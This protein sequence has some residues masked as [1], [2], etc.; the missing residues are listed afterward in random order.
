MLV[1]SDLLADLGG[2]SDG[3]YLTCYPLPNASRHVLARTWSAG[4]GYRPG[5][6]WTHSL[7]LDYQALAVFVDLVALEPLLMRSGDIQRGRPAKPLLVRADLT[8]DGPLE[9]GPNAAIAIEGLYRH[10]HDAVTVPAV[11]RTENDLLA[12]ALW[13]QMWPRLRREFT[14][15]TGVGEG[16]PA[17]SEDWVLRFAR[18]PAHPTDL[19][20]GLQALLDD[21]PAPGQTSLRRFLSRYAVEA[22]EPRKIA[23]PLAELWTMPPVGFQDRLRAVR[24]LTEDTPLPRL[25]RDLVSAELDAAAEPAT[26]LAIVREFGDQPLDVEPSRVVRMTEAMD[27]PSLRLLLSAAAAAAPDH[28]GSRVFEAAVRGSEIRRLAAASGPAERSAM[29]RLRPDLLNVFDFWPVD[30]AERALLINQQTGDFDLEKGW[31]LFGIGIGPRTT[32]ALLDRDPAPSVPILL[33]LLSEGSDQVAY[34]VAT[35][36]VSQP[37]LIETVLE[38]ADARMI[39]R[40]AGAHVALVV[41]PSCP[42]A[43]CTAVR[44]VTGEL[45]APA[46]LITCYVAS[47][48]VGGDEGLAAARQ[49]YDPL[50]K[51]VRRYRLSRQQEYYLEAALSRRVRSWGLANGLTESA[52]RQWGPDR[53]HAGA[54]TLSTEYDHFRD[55]VDEAIDRFGRPRLREVLLDPEL[56]PIVRSYVEQR[57][58]APVRKSWWF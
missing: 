48:E 36:L 9:F 44:R 22:S 19:D 7:V 58:E 5:S 45:A 42:W 53:S 21:L 33:K 20:P 37:T 49:V 3:S 25:T 35:R 11:S 55:L 38:T 57:L 8:A 16:S 31:N 34:L 28:L 40:L 12:L 30:D 47:L 1:Y 46:M 15:I 51:L 26:L 41:P 32:E 54:L 2:V 39:G 29:L 17:Q 52:L 18:I 10:L 14:F 4:V 6:V 13:R 50:Q 27:V 24:E 43:W 56:P 23:R